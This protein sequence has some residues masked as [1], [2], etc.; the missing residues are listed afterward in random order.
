MEYGIGIM[1]SI[2]GNRDYDL[3]KWRRP[4]DSE[5]KVDPS[6]ET[7]KRENHTHTKNSPPSVEPSK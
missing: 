2:N 3:H 1:I 6:T 5:K 7:R 4:S